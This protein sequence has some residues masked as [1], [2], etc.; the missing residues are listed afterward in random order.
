MTEPAPTSPAKRRKRFGLSL[1]VLMV[2]VL[3]LGGGM[4]WYAYRARVQREAVAAIVAEGGRVYYD[5]EC[6]YGSP[7]MDRQANPPWP[8][9]LYQLL[10]PDQL[11]SVVSVEIGLADE[12][13]VDDAMMERIARLSRIESLWISSDSLTDV[14]LSHLRDLPRLHTLF[15]AE[16]GQGVTGRGLGHLSALPALA[17]LELPSHLSDAD[18]EGLAGLH[19]VAILELKGSKITD[20]GLRR[21]DGLTRCACVELYNTGATSKG[22]AELKSRLIPGARV[23]SQITRAPTAARPD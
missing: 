19:Q 9:W 12:K 16:T 3:L 7:D 10:G 22:M 13:Q 5:W 6:I 8:I 1:R 2:L 15:L 23:I 4:G 18:L 14:G 11:G 21:L 20:A 17:E